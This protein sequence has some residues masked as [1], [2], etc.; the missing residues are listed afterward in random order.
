MVTS[1]SPGDKIHVGDSVTLTFLAV[2]GNLI[3]VGVESSEP[4]GPDPSVLIEGS[5]ESDLT[6]WELN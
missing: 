1:L 2:E 5:A 4:G 6:W 3:R